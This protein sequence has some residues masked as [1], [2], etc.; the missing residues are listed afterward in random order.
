MR[1][2]SWVIRRRLRTARD[3]GMSTA[4]YAVGTGAAA[5]VAGVLFKIGT[6]TEVQA[7]IVGSIKRARER[8]G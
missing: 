2:I 8:A 6:S 5:A 1:G 4:E 7:R 3:A